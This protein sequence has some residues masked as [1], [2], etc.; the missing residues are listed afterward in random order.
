MPSPHDRRRIPTWV[1]L[2]LLAAL[3]GFLAL[4]ANTLI[5]PGSHEAYANA[6]HEE[7][8][9]NDVEWTVWQNGLELF[10]VH[11]LPI[12]N[13]PFDLVLHATHVPTGEALAS[14]TVALKLAGNETVFE[15]GP[16]QADAPGVWTV[17]L[18]LPAAGNY[19]MALAIDSPQIPSGRLTLD[20]NPLTVHQSPETAESAAE[21]HDEDHADEVHFLKEQQWR[22]GLRTTVLQP[23]S[24]A[25]QLVVPGKVVAPH[26]SE[27]MVFSPVPGRITPPPDGPLPQVGDTVEA[28]QTLAVI[29]PSIAGAQSVQLLVNQA[30]LR[31]LDAE[32]AAKQLDIEAKLATA[33]ADLEF[34]NQ[35]VQRLKSLSQTGAVAG[36][37]QTEAEYRRKQAQA[38]LE[39][40]E[41]S[42]KTYHDARTRLTKFLGDFG[43]GQEN[44][45]EQD[46]LE[47][48]LRSPLA[49]RV[50]AADATAGEY[51]ADDHLLFRV[52]DMQ[53]LFIDA[54]VSEY[55]L[56]K[57]E[58]SQGAKFRLSAYPDRVLPI[59]GPGDGRLVFVGAVVDPH[60]RTVTVR[61][62]VN[63]NEGL[64]RLGMFADVMVETG[65]RDAA[66]V[67]PQDAVVDDSGEPIVYVQTGGEAFERR[68]VQ[69]G[70]RDGDN[71]EIRQ[72][73]ALGER[74]VI[75]GAYAIRLSTL[76][77]GVPEHHHH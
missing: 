74:V 2:A 47:V 8:E 22:I 75:D 36:R 18:Q 24:I 14:G 7:E 32:L 58:G 41:R 17:P 15:S 59:Y 3:L 34:A 38:A 76:A 12:A 39:G 63:N 72:G 25:E 44:E 43:A 23:Q 37:K 9:H 19:D 77:G 57:V 6:G 29:E 71:V 20:A 48:A 67:V 5:W 66:I 49:G 1:I 70:L 27:T 21:P 53:K 40:Y 35:E 64:L 55:D 60:S 26:G 16:I 30:Q 56:A 4:L 10:V 69:L 31:T 28:G 61:Y 50:V 54:E 46:S 42:H 33:H 68:G 73:L 13:Q 45:A 62:E 52:V 51:V 11:S 65:R